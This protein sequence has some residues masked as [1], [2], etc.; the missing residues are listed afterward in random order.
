M[1]Q[2]WFGFGGKVKE[3][4]WKF[5]TFM[6]LMSLCQLGKAHLSRKA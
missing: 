6:S 4:E 5:N 1:V 3:R 2:S